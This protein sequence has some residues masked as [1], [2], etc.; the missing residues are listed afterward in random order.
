[1][2]LHSLAMSHPSLG[3]PPRDMTAGFP[4]AAARLKAARGRV[5]A[6]ALEIAIAEDPGMR[7]RYDELGLRQLLRDAELL[8]DRVAMSVA[9]NDP[10]FARDYAGWTVIVYR[11]RKVPMDDLV[12]LCEGIRQA[13]TTVLSGDELGAADAALDD[14]I[15]VYRWSRRLAGD[16]R[17]KNAFLQFIYKGG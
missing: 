16:A 5:A 12:R 7:D 9:A 4:D 2:P 6:R 15:D 14:A 1:M 8:V 13:A 3:R 17:K 10:Y 11:R